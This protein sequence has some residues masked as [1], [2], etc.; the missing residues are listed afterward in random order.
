M[1]NHYKRS[2]VSIIS[3]ALIIMSLAPAILAAQQ[4]T[5]G[6]EGTVSDPQGA[7]VPGAM[8]TAR[9]VATNLTRSVKSGDDGHY[10]ISQLPPGNYEVKV[11]AQSFKSTLV[12]GIKVDVGA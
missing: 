12:S 10:R 11:T 3:L 5:G 1:R 9:E 2:L 6:I 8:V 4:P 7:V